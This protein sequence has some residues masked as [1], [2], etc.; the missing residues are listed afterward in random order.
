ME[1]N[2]YHYLHNKSANIAQVLQGEMQKMQASGELQELIS[3]QEHSF[4][5]RH[6]N[7]K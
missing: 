5:N 2:L 7:Q 6:Q 1:I 4:L 3:S